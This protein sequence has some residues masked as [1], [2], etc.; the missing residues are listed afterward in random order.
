MFANRVS[1][2]FARATFILPA[3]LLAATFASFATLARAHSQPEGMASVASKEVATVAGGC[4]WCIEAVF[5]EMDGVDSAI[6][7]Y[8]G[9]QSK[10][11]TYNEVSFK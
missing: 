8:I 1:K 7:G 10:N 9:G 5:N 3:P 2:S 11:P 4:F 6:S